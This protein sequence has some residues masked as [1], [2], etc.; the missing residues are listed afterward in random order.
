MSWLRRVAAEP[1]AQFLVIGALLFAGYSIL[2]GS[3]ATDQAPETITVTEG[4]LVQLAEV[5]ARTWQRPPTAD[6]LRNMVDG[7]VREEIYYREGL[8]LGLDLDDTVLRRRIQQKMEF[9]MEPS[10]AELTPGEGDLAAYL[11]THRETYRL[12][13]QIALTQVYFDPGRSSA[14]ADA[15]AALVRLEDGEVSG[16]SLSPETL[17]DPTMLPASMPLTPMPRI[18]GTIGPEFAAAIEAAPVGAWTGPV[19]SP[20]GWHL[21]RVD[22]REPGRDPSLDEVAALVRRDWEDER[23]RELAT[24]RF[25]AL[26][27]RYSVVV[28]PLPDAKAAAVPSREAVQ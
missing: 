19:R 8:K 15:R 23:R 3:E 16:D 6:E 13:A 26:R 14:E 4:R 11:A 2:R 28:A 7:F 17:G 12:P 10:A 20:Y 5:F 27:S 1:L 24:A 18:A 22:A 9:L 21:V 25:E